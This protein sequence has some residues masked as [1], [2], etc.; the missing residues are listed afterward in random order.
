MLWLIE[1]YLPLLWPEAQTVL[2]MLD[3]RG[4]AASDPWVTVFGSS[5]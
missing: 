4:A 2:R 3:V 5:A 1:G